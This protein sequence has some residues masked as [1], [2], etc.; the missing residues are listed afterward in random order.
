MLMFIDESGDPGLK[1]GSGSSKY[2]I[3]ALVAFE[4]HDEALAADDRIDLLRREIGLSEKFEF[5]FNAFL[6]LS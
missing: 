4:D 2:F 1:V 5:H 6:N 3:V